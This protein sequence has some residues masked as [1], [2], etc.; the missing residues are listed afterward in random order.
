MSE[1]LIDQAERTYE[2][3]TNGNRLSESQAGVTQAYA[4]A[5]N[6][7]RLDDK[8]GQAITYDAAG[9]R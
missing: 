2:Y 8:A 5:P 4:Y 3:D 7:N 1:T 9:N 6:S